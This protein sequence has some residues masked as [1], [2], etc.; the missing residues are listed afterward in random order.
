MENHD[1]PALQDDRIS[2]TDIYYIISGVPKT[3]VRNGASPGAEG[4]SRWRPKPSLSEHPEAENGDGDEFRRLR[5]AKRLAA[6][7]PPL[8]QNS[9]PWYPSEGRPH[10]KRPSSDAG[11]FDPA[12]TYRE[13]RMKAQRMPWTQP[14]KTLI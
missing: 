14:A 10:E 12:G 4:V 7:S 6:A 8:R 3:Q 2:H 1:Q 9:D 11:P 5:N 13:I